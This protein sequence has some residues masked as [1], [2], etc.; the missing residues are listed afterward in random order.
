LII[1]IIA[2]EL[3]INECAVYQIVTQDLNFTKVCAKMVPK[4]SSDD[5]KARRKEVSAEMLERPE[6]EPDFLNW[7]ITGDESWFFEYDPETKR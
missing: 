7:V 3:K 1:Q 5:Q 6:T 4:S 2:D